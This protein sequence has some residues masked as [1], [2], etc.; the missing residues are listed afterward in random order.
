MSAF[1]EPYPYSPPGKIT[2]ARWD[3]EDCMKREESH[4]NVFL[5]DFGR[6][7]LSDVLLE[8]AEEYLTR[9][10]SKHFQGINNNIISVSSGT[11]V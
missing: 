9:V 3:Y 11:T 4:P 6:E 5:K 7:D 1:Q 2:Y 8:N 10:M